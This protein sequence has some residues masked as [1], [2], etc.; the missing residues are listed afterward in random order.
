[1]FTFIQ[2]LLEEIRRERCGEVVQRGLLKSA[3]QMLVDVGVSSPK[4]IL[5]KKTKKRGFCCCFLLFLLKGLRARFRVF[6]SGIYGG[7][8][9]R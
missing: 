4:V 9:L 5:N 2:T 6:V 1:V 3:T 7:V 8:L